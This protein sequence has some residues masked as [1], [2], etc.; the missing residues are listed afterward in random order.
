[1]YTMKAA[2][3][4]FNGILLVLVSVGV[5]DVFFAY[6]R[7]R[8]SMT[9]MYE[10]PEYQNI[11]LPKKAARIFPAYELYLYGEGVYAEK[12]KPLSLDGIPVLFLPGNAGSYKQ[13]RSIGSIA[14]RKAENI[15]YRYHFDV[16]SV[17][18]NEELVAFYGG[19]LRRQ[20][21]FVNICIKAILHLYKNH[22]FPPK[23]VIIIGH[24]MGGLI[25]RALFTLKTFNPQLINLII[26]Q[27]TPHL[28]PVL[29]IDYYLTD[30]YALVNNYW[31]LNAKELQN[32]TVLS[33][34]GGFRDFQVRSGLTFLPASDLYTNTLS[35]VSTSVPRTWASTDHLSIVWCKELIL[36]T[37]RALFDLIDEKT[38]QV[39]NDPETRMSVLNH[40]FVRHPAKHYEPSYET[41][42]IAPLSSTW[43]FIETRNWKHSV[44][45]ACSETYF[46]FP[47]LDKRDVHSHFHC[48]STHFYTYSWIFGCEDGSTKCSKIE[49]LSWNAELLPS[50]KSVTLKLENF[51]TTT[52]F[53]IY[54]PQANDTEFSVECE[55]LK[56]ELKTQQLPVTHALSFGFSSSH[57]K[58]NSSGLLHFVQLQGFSK[59]YQAFD[60]LI[61]KSC[62]KSKENTPEMFRFQVPWT[63]E[64]IIRTS[65][66]DAHLQ[67]FAKLHEQKPQN[68]SRMVTLILYTSQD[69][70]YEVTIYTSFLQMMGQMIR[71][72]GATLPVYILS[73]LLLA[74]GAQLHFLSS[75][76]HCLEFDASLDM[77]AKPYKVDPIVNICRFLLG[78]DWFKNTWDSVLLPQL[79]SSELYSLGLLFPVASLLLFMFGTGV[80]YWSGIFFKAVIGLLAAMWRTVKRNTDVPNENSSF[81]K[82]VFVEAILFSL[83]CWSTCGALSILIVFI[84][85]LI[86][87]VKMQCELWKHPLSNNGI[88]SETLN[89]KS[90]SKE[91]SGTTTDSDDI[92]PTSQQ[93]TS[94]N[95]NFDSDFMT[96]SD[97]LKMHITI[98]NLLLWLT[99]LILPSFIY[100]VK[101]L[102]YK[103]QLDP[104]PIR[105]LAIPLVFTV[106][107]LMNST[108]VS[109]K[110]SKL[111]KTAAR[112]QLPFSIFIVAFGTLHLYRVS[113]FIVFSLFLH[114]MT[115]FL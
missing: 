50:A 53:V 28:M 115:C 103:I 56:E 64:D 84:R 33:V 111:L 42:T 22:E 29:T 34:A 25:A 27:A 79:D 88:S 80:A 70:Q 99:L 93:E 1:M 94:N 82:K 3:A 65:S 10:Y 38:K 72:H 31:I 58:I 30:F 76:G 110:S 32:V 74:Y 55:F 18:F 71:F 106:I 6:E 39:T 24:S 11:K 89:S 12:N 16:F 98:M 96:A 52:H 69:C 44:T 83:V 36:A 101:N 26:T 102:R 57:M 85:Y 66:D 47:L 113:Y 7:N 17:N 37:A 95:P 23:S 78:Y 35:V 92:V 54:Q 48:R 9:Y 13:A 21:E 14:L 45:G 107:I 46:A 43:V 104:D 61:E 2:S 20:T 73:N 90:L 97:N 19:S 63:H 59:I 49:D 114:A 109:M 105:L 77:A 41:I 112:L 40:H 60:I 91:H 108:V 15:D 68:D 4:L 87:V 81:T 62:K 8:C 86:K 100:W 67:I 5:R 75:K 51:P